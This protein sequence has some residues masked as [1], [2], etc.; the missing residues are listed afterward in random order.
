MSA[1]P[2]LGSSHPDTLA[3]RYLVAKI[4]GALGR[5]E[6]ALPVADTVDDPE[7]RASGPPAKPPEVEHPSEVA[8]D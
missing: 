8:L 4:V 7:I 1:H 5:N 3:S 2:D 6:E